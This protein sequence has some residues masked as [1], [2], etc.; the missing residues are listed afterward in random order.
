MEV[1]AVQL[2]PTVCAVALVPVPERETFAGEFPASLT[3]V[4][5]P[6]AVPVVCGVNVTATEVDFPAL[7]ANGVAVVMLN[8]RPVTLID[9]TLTVAVPELES[10][11][12][13]DALLPTFTFPNDSEEG[14]TF[15]NPTGLE[16]PVP[17]SAT[18]VGEEPRLLT[19]DADPLALPA[20]CGVKTTF[21]V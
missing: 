3:N 17:A 18:T 4:A 5:V 6:F 10:V 8:P 2:K 9:C 13:F 20:L 15:S 12:L 1:L 14:E 7:T 19:T 16:T 11:R 21:A